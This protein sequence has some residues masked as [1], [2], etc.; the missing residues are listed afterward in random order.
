MSRWYMDLS[1]SFKY[2]VKYIQKELYIKVAG[3]E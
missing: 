1:L 2:V 3:A